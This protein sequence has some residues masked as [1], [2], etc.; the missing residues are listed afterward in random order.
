MP[1]SVIRLSTIWKA[2]CRPSG[3]ASNGVTGPMSLIP[4]TLPIATAAKLTGHSPAQIRR[5]ISGGTLDGSTASLERYIGRPITPEL[6]LAAD[7]ARDPA[8]AYQRS[9]HRERRSA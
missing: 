6:Y 5:L 9:Y 4:P 2:L 3:R 7:R 1:H 8:R